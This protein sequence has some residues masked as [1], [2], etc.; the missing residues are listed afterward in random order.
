MPD[1]APFPSAITLTDFSQIIGTSSVQIFTPGQLRF[2]IRFMQ[3]TNPATNSGYVWLSR[4]GPA[5]A[6]AVGS[7]L[8][9]PG[10]VER[11]DGSFIPINPLWAVSTAANTLLTVVAGQ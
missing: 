1:P 4:S 9:G 10:S 3:I 8:L 7:Y 11:W 6:N 2:G 5:V